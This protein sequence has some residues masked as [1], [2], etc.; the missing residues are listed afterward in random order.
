MNNYSIFNVEDV[1]KSLSSFPLDIARTIC[2]ANVVKKQLR[3]NTAAGARAF[4]LQ[5]LVNLQ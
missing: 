4:C 2:Y 5:Y 3:R 1:L